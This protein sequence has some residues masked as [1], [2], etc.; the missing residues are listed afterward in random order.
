MTHVVSETETD[1][2][3]SDAELEE[4]ALAADPN[5]PLTADAMPWQPEREQSLP[6]SYLPQPSIRSRPASTTRTVTVLVVIAAFLAITAL[7]F[8]ATY[9]QLV[10]A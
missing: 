1:A 7:G 8:C 5:T 10:H 2:V 6:T 3:L 9:G 4:L